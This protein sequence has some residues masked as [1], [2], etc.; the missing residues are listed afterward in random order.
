V[1]VSIGVA[2]FERE[3]S[4]SSWRI[5]AAVLRGKVNKDVDAGALMRQRI[6]VAG[7]ADLALVFT[8][9]QSLTSEALSCAQ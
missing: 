6:C 3:A 5:G 8:K 4:L 2:S 1:A 9:P 7:F